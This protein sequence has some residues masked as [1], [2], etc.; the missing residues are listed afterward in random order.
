MRE[1]E[2]STFADRTRVVVTGMNTHA[3][4]HKPCT[5]LKAL[6]NPSRRPE[7]QWYDVRFDDYTVARLPGRYLVPEDAEQMQQPAN[8]SAA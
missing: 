6:P 1:K 8:S 3:K 5:I 7:K 2:H 4:N